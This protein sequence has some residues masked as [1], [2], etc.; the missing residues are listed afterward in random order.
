MVSVAERAQARRALCVGGVCIALVL[1]SCGGDEG[2]GARRPEPPRGLAPLPFERAEPTAGGR[3]LRLV[4]ASDPC[5][6]PIRRARV[7][8]S[9][10]RVVVT[11]FGPRVRPDVACIQVL[12]VGCAI[13]PLQEPLHDRAVVDGAESDR[14]RELLGA[15]GRD[16]ALRRCRRV[17]LD[18]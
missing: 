8:E 2:G 5:H 10:K 4:A 9:D 13:V 6:L 15:A 16:R 7:E 18:R 14:R 17:P 3:E 1:S 11:L 12:R